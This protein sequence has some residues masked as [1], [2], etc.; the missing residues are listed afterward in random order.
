[1][2]A[3]QW[4]VHADENKEKIRD[5]LPFVDQAGIVEGS[6]SISD[7]IAKI[8]Q[9]SSPDDHI[10]SSDTEDEQRPAFDAPPRPPNAFMLYRKAQSKASRDLGFGD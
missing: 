1:M 5:I 7:P 8:R 4:L 2:W 9:K 3:R 10:S 6:E